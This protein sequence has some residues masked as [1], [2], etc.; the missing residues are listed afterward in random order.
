MLGAL[1]PL[2]NGMQLEIRLWKLDVV[3]YVSRK[4]K[5]ITLTYSS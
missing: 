2:E 3:F 5:G 4:Q 1:M